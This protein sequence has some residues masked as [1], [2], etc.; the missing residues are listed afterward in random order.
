MILKVRASARL[1][2]PTISGTM[3]CRSSVSGLMKIFSKIGSNAQELSLV[4][5]LQASRPPFVWDQMGT[6]TTQ[7]RIVSRKE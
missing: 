2:P 1:N 7:M 3:G 5:G 4:Q 6:N